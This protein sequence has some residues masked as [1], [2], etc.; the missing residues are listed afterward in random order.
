MTLQRDWKRAK[1]LD[2]NQL[3]SY[4]P[5]FFTPFM[6]LALP[7]ECC[8]VCIYT[9]YLQYLA[10]NLSHPMKKRVQ[11]L[12]FWPLLV[13]TWACWCWAQTLPSFSSSC[14]VDEVVSSPWETVLLKCELVKFA[15]RGEWGKKSQCVNFKTLKLFSNPEI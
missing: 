10:K 15:Y 6:V 11:I 14:A 4:I 12:M 9:V 3:H 5:P 2:C 8:F 1:G 13:L 7:W